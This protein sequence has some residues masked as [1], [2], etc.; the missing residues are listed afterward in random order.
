[1]LLAVGRSCVQPNTRV[2]EQARYR[3]MRYDLNEPSVKVR[4]AWSRHRVSAIEPHANG[5]TQQR[6]VQQAHQTRCEPL[7]DRSAASRHEHGHD[8]HGY[9]GHGE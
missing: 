3:Y 4:A 9:Q 5:D 7:A 1:M 8:G 2:E 6:V